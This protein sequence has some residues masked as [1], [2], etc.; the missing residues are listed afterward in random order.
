M[1]IGDLFFNLLPAELKKEF[2]GMIPFHL[3][4]QTLIFLLFPL[5]PR[6]K[7]PFYRFHNKSLAWVSEVH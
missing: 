1:K 3:L 2:Q 6:I 7:K 4:D 5:A